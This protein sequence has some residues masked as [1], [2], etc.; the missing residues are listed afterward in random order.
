MGPATDEVVLVGK[1]FLLAVD[2]Q[3]REPVQEAFDKVQVQ[4]LV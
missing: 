3:V 1:D 4:D 2:Q